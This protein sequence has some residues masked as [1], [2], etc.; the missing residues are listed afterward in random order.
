MLSLS[1]FQHYF[2]LHVAWTCCPLGFLFYWSLLVSLCSMF[3]ISLKKIFFINSHPRIC[4]HWF[5]L[6][7]RVGGERVTEIERC[8]RELSIS[9]LPFMPWPGIKPATKTCP[10]LGNWTRS[11]LLVYRTVL[12]PTEPPPGQGSVFL[13]FWNQESDWPSSLQILGYIAEYLLAH[14][15]TSLMS[16]AHSTSI[17]CKRRS[18]L[19]WYVIWPLVF[20][21]N[22]VDWTVTLHKGSWHRRHCDW[23][24]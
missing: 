22:E 3:W 13:D 11:N 7:Q 4:F 19:V 18:R 10:L 24:G 21:M 17:T 6:R 9:C 12:Q 20:P 2:H 14:W 8:K 23:L 16:G 1:W 15:N 5:F